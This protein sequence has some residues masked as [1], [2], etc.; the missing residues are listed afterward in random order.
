MSP[1]VTAVFRSRVPGLRACSVVLSA[2]L[3][4]LAGCAGTPDRR[5]DAQIA[6]DVVFAVPTPRELGFSVSAQQ[7]VTARYGGEAQLFQAQLTVSPKRL[8]LIAFDALG[9]RA[10]SL[11]S[12]EA[13]VQLQAAPWLPD[14]IRPAN[15]LADIAIVYWPEAAVR[16]GLH[17][18][19][20][21]VQTQDR[22]RSIMMGPREIIRVDYSTPPAQGWPATAHLQNDAF[23]Y[24]LDLRSRM[25]A[26]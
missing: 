16:Q 6:P 2:A 14:A 15:I 13:G 20:A 9:R 19:S 11:T 22:R 3:F 12:S 17:G 25:M 1:A 5:Q 10:F 24:E 23:G 18:S 26:Q 8:T 7:L 4:T 21:T